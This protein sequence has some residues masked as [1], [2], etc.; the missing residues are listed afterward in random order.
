MICLKDYMEG[1]IT[2]FNQGTGIQ[3]YSNSR[4]LQCLKQNFDNGHLHKKCAKDGDSVTLNGIW[5]VHSSL[6]KVCDKMPNCLG[7]ELTILKKFSRILVELKPIFSVQ[8][9]D[10]GASSLP[11]G[12]KR[13]W[14]WRS[15]LWSGYTQRLLC[16]L[17]LVLILC[18]MVP[19]PVYC[20][21]AECVTWKQLTLVLQTSATSRTTTRE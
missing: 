6:E 19:H 21:V 4:L 3:R 11:I 17:S 1:C 15:M 2:N 16:P 13:K 20:L 10:I 14:L 5:Q 12:S 8:M 9:S 7:S 18:F